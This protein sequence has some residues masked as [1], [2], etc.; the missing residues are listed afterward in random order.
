M[1]GCCHF[2]GD[3]RWIEHEVVGALY[4]AT[5]LKGF[6]MYVET[7]TLARAIMA[8]LLVKEGLQH[9]KL[10][11]PVRGD[12]DEEPHFLAELLQF[13][14]RLTFVRVVRQCCM[15]RPVGLHDEAGLVGG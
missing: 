13:E 14:Q 7:R 1:R 10:F 2:H 4:A 11:V 6:T 15:D 8:M 3:R 12:L 5:G 9:V